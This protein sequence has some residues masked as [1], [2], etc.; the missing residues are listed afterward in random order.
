MRKTTNKFLPEVRARA[1]RVILDHE[2]D[3]PSR[4]SVMVSVTDKIGC[5][6]QRLH[7]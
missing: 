7:E 6:P 5:A 3:Y 1:V 4:W 2:V